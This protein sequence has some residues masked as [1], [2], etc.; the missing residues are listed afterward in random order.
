L[1]RID[2]R[3][4]NVSGVKFNKLDKDKENKPEVDAQEED[5]ELTDAVTSAETLAQEYMSAAEAEIKEK[6]KKILDK[7]LEDA[8]EQAA[9]IIFNAREEAEELEKKAWQEGFEI[10][11]SEGKRAYDEKLAEKIQEDDE[12]LKRILDEIYLEREN[13]YN[14]LEEQVTDLSLEI[15]RKVIGPA[16]DELQTVFTSLIKNALKQMSSDSK[17]VIRVGPNEYER[18]FSSG[19]ATIELDSGTVV[20]ASVLRDVSLG[21]G[22]CIIDTDEVTVN[23]GLESQLQY[24]KLAFERTNQYEPE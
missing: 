21:D 18:F 11:T 23:A 10:G 22:D 3:L 24:V 16:E 8:R 1:F 12:A 6:E 17:V 15:V 14:Q 13:T 20:K 7:A 9:T 2:R 19:A 4:V 5:E